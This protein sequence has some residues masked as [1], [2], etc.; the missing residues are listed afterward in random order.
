MI[1]P[2][3]EF[4]VFEHF[5]VYF[6]GE[7]LTDL[8]RELIHK[9]GDIFFGSALTVPILQGLHYSLVQFHIDVVFFL[10]ILQGG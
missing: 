8:A 2:L 6:L 4:D 5:L 3:E 9:G 10:Q 1:L 7:F